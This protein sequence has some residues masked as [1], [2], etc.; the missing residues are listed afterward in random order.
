MKSVLSEFNITT[1]VFFWLVFLWYIF[2]H[3]FTFILLE[4]LYFKW[5]ACRKYVVIL[6]FFKNLLWHNM[7]YYLVIKSKE[8][9]AFVATWMDLEIVMLSEVRQWGTKIICYHLNVE[10]IKRT[11]WTLQNRYC[12]TDSGK[13]MVSKEDRLRVSGWAGDLGRK[14]YKIGLWWSLYNYKCNKIHWVI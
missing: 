9:M 2:L 6:C 11:Q 14:C 8:V 1:S 10:P 3:Y 12:L 4:S 13:L 5:I 7:E